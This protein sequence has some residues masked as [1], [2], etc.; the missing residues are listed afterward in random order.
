MKEIKRYRIGLAILMLLTLTVAA[1]AYYLACRQSIPDNIQLVIN[2]SSEFDYKIPAIG[3]ITSDDKE[4]E[5]VNLKSKFVLKSVQSGNY[6]METKLFGLV[7]LKEVAIQSLERQTAAPSGQVAGIYIETNGLFVIDTTDV[8]TAAGKKSP[9]ENKLKSGDYITKVNGQ[10]VTSK[11]KFMEQVNQSGG[12]AVI[13]QVIRKNQ[14]FETKITP[15]L[16]EEDNQYKIGAYIRNNTQGIGTIT[17]TQGKQFAAL[18]HGISDIDLGNLLSI[19]GGEIYQ[20]E[21]S[22]IK[23][24]SAGAPG[25]IVGL[26]DY[27]SENCKG[28]IEKNTENGIFGTFFKEQTTEDDL[29]IATKQEVKPGNAKIVSYISGKRQEYNIQITNVDKGNHEKRKGMS[30]K[31][32][33]AKLKQLTNGIVQGMSGSPII[34]DG[35]LIG[36]VTHVFVSDPTKGYGIFAET[37]VEESIK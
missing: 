37:M 27:K 22:S 36:A 18:G 17:Y 15:V 35:K 12:K 31:V 13:L 14:S 1:W 21:I 26:I 24:G 2:D 5:S 10:K 11:M 30:I 9:S 3:I 4:I 34:Q 6:K 7:K 16:D 32:T 8:E 23:K 19:C 25:E 33:D 29:P 20:A 28:I